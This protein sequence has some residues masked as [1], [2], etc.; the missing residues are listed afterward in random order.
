MRIN[1]LALRLE[2]ES[3]LVRL[4]AALPPASR[5]SVARLYAR[6]C[7]RAAKVVAPVIEPTEPKGG[8][9]HAA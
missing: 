1:Q 4:W 2:D 3:E 6:L 9:D 8:A 7:I 5:M